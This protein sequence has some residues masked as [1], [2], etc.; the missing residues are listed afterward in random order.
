MKNTNKFYEQDNLQLN[1]LKSKKI[2]KWRPKYSIKESVNLTVNW[3]KNVNE[4]K[5][6]VENETIK[7]I[8]NYMN[9]K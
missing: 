3:Y 5:N 7:Q 2:L 1:I 8:N 6:N 4:N 9:I